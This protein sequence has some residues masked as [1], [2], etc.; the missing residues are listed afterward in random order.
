MLKFQRSH[1]IVATAIAALAAAT[2]VR[3]D[4]P[5]VSPVRDPVI[6]KECG[7]CHMAYPAGFLPARSWSAIVA[8][9]ANHFGENASLDAATAA[10]VANYLTQNAEPARRGAL[11]WFGRS[12]QPAS[13][14]EVLRITE[15]GWFVGEHGRF[16]P[17]ALQRH[18]AKVAGDCQA[19]HKG[20]AAGHFED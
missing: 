4:G 5:R 1:A 10:K 14:P 8:G 15:L 6:A 17:D 18:G 19:C 9:L 13:G 16:D 2:A 3:A 11:G 12:R 20:A 7:A